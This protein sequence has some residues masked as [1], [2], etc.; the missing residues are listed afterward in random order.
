MCPDVAL[1]AVVTAS[2]MEVEFKLFDTCW[3]VD[4]FINTLVKKS[5]GKEFIPRFLQ[6]SLINSTK[7]S[8]VANELDLVSSTR[9][10]FG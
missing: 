9:F 5:R 8:S 7:T 10:I 1:S 4:T 6:Y 3:V 2:P